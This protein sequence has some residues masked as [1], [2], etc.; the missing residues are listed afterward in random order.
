MKQPD[1]GK[2]I[3]ELRQAKGLTQGELAEKCNISTRTIQRIESADVTPRSYTIRLIFSSLEYDIYNSF[4]RFSYG[5]DRTVYK[6]RI[7]LG[8]LYTYIIDLF[9]LKTNTMKKLSILSAT[10]V[11][12]SFLLFFAIAESKGQ[13]ASKV[14][15]SI[16][17][18]NRDYVRWFNEGKIDSVLTLCRE[19]VCLIGQGCGKSFVR[20]ALEVQTQQFKL[21]ELKIV[22]IS[23]ADS[24]AVEK[25]RWVVNANSIDLEGEYL[26]E[27]RY[28]NKKWLMVNTISSN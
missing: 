5:L 16:E 24:I 7:W 10:F 12:V 18:A 21:K 8:Q 11:V 22:S 23:V 25:G 9:N 26:S 15:K 13:S 19:D 14:K 1:L 4:G 17:A 2:K 20:N 28:S 6:I 27:W 3:S